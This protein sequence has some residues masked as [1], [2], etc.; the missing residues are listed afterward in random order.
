L[1]LGVKFSFGDSV[2]HGIISTFKPT[3]DFRYKECC[4][5]LIVERAEQ[6]I[7]LNFEQYIKGFKS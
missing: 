5:E 2:R 4:G 1:N 7:S 3:K 6:Y